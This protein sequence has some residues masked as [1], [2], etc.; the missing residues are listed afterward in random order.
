V[1]DV[2]A[3]QRIRSIEDSASERRGQWQE[4]GDL[5]PVQFGAT[6]PTSIA[7]LEL[8]VGAK[9]EVAIAIGDG[10]HPSE[11][12]DGGFGLIVDLD[13]DFVLIHL[14]FLCGRP[15]LLAFPLPQAGLRSHRWA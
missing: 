13:V 5:D 4:R 15:G 7:G 3:G 14:N 6:D 10:F 8:L 12:E 9:T 2:G 1:T 11:A